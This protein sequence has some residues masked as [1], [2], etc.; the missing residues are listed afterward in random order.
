M[1]HSL[2]VQFRLAMRTDLPA[3][4]RMLAEDE[5]GAQRERFET[6]LPPAYYDAFEAIERD[7]NNELIVAEA[8]GE[9]IGTLQLMFLLSISYQGRTRAQVESVR[10]AQH[11]RGQGVGA[12]MMEWAL[13]RAR[14]RGCHMMQLTSHA[15][16]EDAHRF[17]EKLGFTKSHIGMKINL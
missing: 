11:L 15:S 16:R 13:A 14:Q 7:P 8:A 4:V 6:P 2:N 3:I 9:V 10:V 17:Y 5:I 12:E 1:P